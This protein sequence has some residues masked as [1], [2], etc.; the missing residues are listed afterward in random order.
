MI[1]RQRAQ[2]EALEDRLERV[3][4]QAQAARERAVAAGR[5]ARRQTPTWRLILAAAAVAVIVLRLL[6]GVG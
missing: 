4:A 3:R 1:E 6:M 2:V 5:E